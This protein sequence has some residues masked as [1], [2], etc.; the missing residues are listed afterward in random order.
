MEH[1]GVSGKRSLRSL[2]ARPLLDEASPTSDACGQ[3]PLGGSERS[4]P[5]VPG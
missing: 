2:A 3:G 5:S 1:K 4:T